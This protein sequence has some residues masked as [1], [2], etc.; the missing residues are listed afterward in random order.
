[1]QSRDL[2]LETASVRLRKVRTSDATAFFSLL[3]DADVLQ[4][5]GI[6]LPPSVEKTRRYIEDLV[7]KWRSSKTMAFTL[8]TLDAGKQET[9]G[10]LACLENVDYRD[11]KAEIGIWLGKQFWSTG[12][13]QTGLTLLLQVAF[14]TLHLRRVFARAAVENVRMHK[15]LESLGFEREGILRK[16]AEI[17]GEPHDM[18]LYAILKGN[19]LHL[20]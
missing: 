12:L 20:K 17:H 8:C 9:I 6:E 16:D 10:G 14:L 1:M 13:A 5:I 15:R 18:V 4:F 3:N 11:S 19:Y 7:K 2:I